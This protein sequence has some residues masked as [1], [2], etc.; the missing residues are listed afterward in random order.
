MTS[1]QD[2]METNR[3]GPFHDDFKNKLGVQTLSDLAFVQ[4]EDLNGLGFLPVQVRRFLCLVDGAHNAGRVVS[5]ALEETRLVSGLVSPPSRQ[6][7]QETAGRGHGSRGPSR[8]AMAAD[9]ERTVLSDAH[10]DAQRAPHVV[11]E[12]EASDPLH[13]GGRGFGLRCMQSSIPGAEL[14]PDGGSDSDYTMGSSEDGEAT[15]EDDAVVA[16]RRAKRRRISRTKERRGVDAASLANGAGRL[17][18]PEPRKNGTHGG[19]TLSASSAGTA[20]AMQLSIGGCSCAEVFASCGPR[21]ATA[22]RTFRERR[23]AAAAGRCKG[24]QSDFNYARL[25]AVVADFLFD[26]RGNWVVHSQCA[27]Q[28]LGVS[29]WWLS[30]RHKQA[31]RIAKS[32]TI[33]LSKSQMAASH[34]IDALLERVILPDCCLLSVTQYFHNSP[35]SATFE[36]SSSPDE[37]GLRGKA[38]NRTKVKEQELFKIFIR[39]NRS[40]TGRSADKTGRFH[41]AAYYL[42]S[43]FK[44]LRTP[45]PKD[46]VADTRLSLSGAFNDALV[47]A[48]L[49]RVHSDMPA[50]WLLL[51]FG[52]RHRIDGVM[53]PSDEHTTIYPHKTDAC[54]TCELLLADL[55][56]SEQSLKRHEQQA[57]KDTMT[58]QVAISDTKRIIRDLQDALDTHKDEASSAVLYHHDCVD[59]A[60][61]RYAALSSMFNEMMRLGPESQPLMQMDDAVEERLVA[62]A[63]EEWFEVSSDYQQDK[64]VPAWNDSPQPGP[65]YFMSGETHYVHIFCLESCGK[66]TGPTRFSRNVVYS[67]NECVGGSKTSD[68]TLSTLCDVLLGGAT[69]GGEDPPVL[70][71]GCL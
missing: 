67:R 22:R 60:V 42:D 36:L 3:F 52:S 6:V 43:K 69:V 27:R 53:Q 14:E 17:R 68:D 30:S 13:S 63:S 12:G 47:S 19:A 41:G 51:L 44:V 9:A 40:P 35:L 39:K 37:H 20:R 55:R 24:A 64:A 11:G 7:D 71:Q 15:S 25:G 48:G 61:G 18:M 34:N 1:L 29:S 4:A 66:T 32:P 46:G 28:H 65:T 16:R 5:S 59:N 23:Q 70:R 21:L 31:V 62:A 10:P 38:S 57:D 54:P 49:P 2:W 50:K 26:S 33:C 8:P 45:K 56:H 58:R